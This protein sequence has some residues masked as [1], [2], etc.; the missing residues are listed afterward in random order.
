MTEA[1]RREQRLARLVRPGI[2][3]VLVG[4]ALSSAGACSGSNTGGVLACG[5]GTHAVSGECVAQDASA[6]P[7]DANGEGADGGVL[8]EGGAES[9]SAP[10]A[11]GTGETSVESQ[12][13]ATT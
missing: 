12:N 7:G 9:G 1:H 5:A 3:D 4:A 2:L 10:D 6:P 11:N 13:D 8:S